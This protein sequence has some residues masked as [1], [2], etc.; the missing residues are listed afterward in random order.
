MDNL[1]L[2]KLKW[3]LDLFYPTF[4][5]IEQK[6]DQLFENSDYKSIWGDSYWD[7]S[8]Q[9]ESTI[10]ELTSHLAVKISDLVRTELQN[11]GEHE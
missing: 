9:I 11:Y 4:Q 3:L 6:A 5:E 8:R 1:D 7:K 10:N 2:N